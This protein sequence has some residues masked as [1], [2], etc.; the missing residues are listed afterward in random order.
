MART[1][2]SPRSAQ[3]GHPDEKGPAGRGQRE[4]AGRWAGHFGVSGYALRVRVR[5]ALRSAPR[6]PSRDPDPF[7]ALTGPRHRAGGPRQERHSHVIRSTRARARASPRGRGPG[8]HRA[9]ARPGRR[10]PARARRSRRARGRPDGDRQDR[11]LR[12]SHPPAPG[13][14]HPG[15]A[16]AGRR[17]ACSSSSRPGS[18]R[19]RWRRASGPTA[20]VTGSAPPRSTAASGSTRRSARCAPARRSSSPPRGGSSTT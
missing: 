19:S 16:T 1:L 10:H 15:R 13:A 5:Q 2:G 20:P 17:S 3:Q 9:H 8:L 11:R 14:D 18:W 12:A 7:S 4:P 6:F